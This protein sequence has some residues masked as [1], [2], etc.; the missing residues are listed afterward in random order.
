[1]S[2]AG[3]VRTCV[4][5]NG[6]APQDELLRLQ[7]DEAGRLQGVARPGSGRSAYLHRDER[8]WE[9]FAKG[10]SA[11]LWVRSLRAAVAREERRR[12]IETIRAS[13]GDRMQ[14]SKAP[15]ATDEGAGR[16]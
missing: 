12:M 14:G 3:P 15:Q 9:A 11:K 13:A 6:R 1:M 5:C 10:R 16:G 7:L 4:G 8:C 2:K